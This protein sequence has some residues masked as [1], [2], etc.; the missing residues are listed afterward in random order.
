MVTCQLAAGGV[1][2]SRICWRNANARHPD[3]VA[4]QRRERAASEPRKAFDG[5]DQPQAPPDPPARTFVVTALAAGLL[6]AERGISNWQLLVL[7][8]DVLPLRPAGSGLVSSFTGSLQTDLTG[9]GVGSRVSAALTSTA[10][11]LPKALYAS[12]RSDKR[13][14]A[15]V[16]NVGR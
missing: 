8:R 5:D 7:P 1:T 9:S 11:N 2:E 13:A 6:R 14:L 10:T 15:W 16:I 12:N 3:L 4:A